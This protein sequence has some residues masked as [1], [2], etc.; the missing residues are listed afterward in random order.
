MTA[1]ISERA[2]E[3]A[4][5]CGLLQYGPDACP[6]AATTVWETSPPYGQNPP[7]GYHRRKPEGH[8]RALCVSAP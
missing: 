2:F 5:E 4:I 6:G 3:E 1:E 7:G 8:D